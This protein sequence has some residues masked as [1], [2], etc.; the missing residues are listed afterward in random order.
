[1]II[2]SADDLV[3]PIIAFAPEGTYGPASTNP[4]GALASRD[5]PGRV[6]RVRQL[7]VQARQGDREFSP[8][9]LE[10]DAQRKW[11]LLDRSSPAEA[12]EFGL[13]NVS[14]L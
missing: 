7:E 13:P 6:A 10:R 5:V 3:E 14:A 11:R 12:Q 1:L 2:M 4:L 8:V 9:G